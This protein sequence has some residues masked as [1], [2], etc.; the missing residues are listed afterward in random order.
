[1]LYRPLTRRTDAS[2]L[3]TAIAEARQRKCAAAVIA[4]AEQRVSDALA[5]ARLLGAL[6]VCKVRSHISPHVCVKSLL[7]FP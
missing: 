3:V 7:S 2:F 1:M 5:E 6:T 4:M